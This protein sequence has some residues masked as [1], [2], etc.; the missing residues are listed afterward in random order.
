M[1]GN[2]DSLVASMTKVSSSES[3]PISNQSANDLLIE[4][5]TKEKCSTNNNNNNHHK[6][7]ITHDSIN[8]LIKFDPKNRTTTTTTKTNVDSINHHHQIIRHHPHQDLNEKNLNHHH[9][10]HHQQQQQQQNRQNDAHH[11]YQH[12]HSN[13]KSNATNHHNPIPSFQQHQQQPHHHQHHQQQQLLSQQ[14]P[15]PPTLPNINHPQQEKKY[16]SYKLVSDPML[17]KGAPKLYRYDGNVS[18]VSLNFKKKK[19]ILFRNKNF[20]FIKKN[21]KNWPLLLKI[22]VNMYHYIGISGNQLI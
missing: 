13:N 6:D 12:H 20:E 8:D 10:H 14:Y 9:H 5:E 1:N 11:H 21:R 16:K 3:S 7:N 17:K 22:L 15:P 2:I 18:S 4:D 19:K